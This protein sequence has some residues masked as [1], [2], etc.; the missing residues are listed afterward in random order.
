MKLLNSKQ[1]TALAARIDKQ[2]FKQA[3]SRI[4]PNPITTA[5]YKA[6]ALIDEAAFYIEQEELAEGT[7]DTLTEEAQANGEYD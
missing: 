5:L 7:L 4:N 2:G 6:V 3:Y 1:L